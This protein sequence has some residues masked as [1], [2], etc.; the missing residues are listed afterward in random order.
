[1]F[2][3]FI[4]ISNEL[5]AQKKHRSKSQVSIKNIPSVNTNVQLVS[6]QMKKAIV[7]SL[8]KAYYQRYI[9]DS[10][11]LGSDVKVTVT[12]SNGSR[13]LNFVTTNKEGIGPETIIPNSIIEGDLNNDSCN[14]LIVNVYYNQGSRP[15]LDIYCYITKNKKLE[16]FE[17]HSIH[18]LGICGN[19]T[20][21]TGRFFPS[22]IENGLLVG[23]TQCLQAGDPGC[24]PSLEMVTY[25]KFEDGFK[26]VRQEPKKE[27]ILTKPKAK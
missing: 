6:E 8:F 17:K 27:I 18:S 2:V 16:F 14:D 20:D 23:E 5:S 4:C 21:T 13:T 22:K 7:D 24:C 1:M 19:I 12:K 15:R 25:F 3:F 9:S 26:F 11:E 10:K